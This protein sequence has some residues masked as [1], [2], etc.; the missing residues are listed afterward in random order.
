VIRQASQ[1]KT[2]SLVKSNGSSFVSR[3]GWR[4][5][6]PTEKP[7]QAMPACDGTHHLLAWR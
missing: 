4:R 6:L 7:W 5:L 3:D 1:P 2:F